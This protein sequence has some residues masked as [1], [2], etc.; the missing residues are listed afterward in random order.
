MI[1]SN[2]VMHIGRNGGSYGVREVGTELLVWQSELASASSAAYLVAFLNAHAR[3]RSAADVRELLTG[4]GSD[5]A[6]HAQAS[7]TPPERTVERRTA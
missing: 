7:D 5:L 3:H 2:Y 4:L 1:M 6:P